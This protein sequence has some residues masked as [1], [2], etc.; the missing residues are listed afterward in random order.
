MTYGLTF[1][2]I[3]ILNCSIKGWAPSLD[4]GTTEWTG[5]RDL[6][7]HG[8]GWTVCGTAITIGGLILFE[9][10]AG[11]QWLFSLPNGVRKQF[12]W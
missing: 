4:F 1:A 6:Q 9:H 5:A 11:H 2:P 12:C 7:P 3:G 10:H 8:S